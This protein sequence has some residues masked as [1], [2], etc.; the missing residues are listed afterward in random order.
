MS[1]PYYGPPYG[2]WPP[3]PYGPPP[4]PKRRTRIWL[5]G[6]VAVVILGI[7]GGAATWVLMAQNADVEPSKI[8]AVADDF[9]RAVEGGDPQKIAALMCADEAGPY[10]DNVE[11]MDG[12]VQTSGEPGFDIG[13]VTVKGDVAAA[14]L[15]FKGGGSQQLYFRKENGKWMVCDP[16]KD[17]L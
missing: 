14:T 1:T 5:L 3:Q 16:A 15:N 13:E 17:Q 9:A 4:E 8:R 7:A 6:V 12:D 2:Q 11:P 10:L